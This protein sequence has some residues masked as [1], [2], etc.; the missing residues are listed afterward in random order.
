MEPRQSLSSRA[1][2]DFD[3]VR[4]SIASPEKIR[5]WSWGE[6]TKPETIN[7]RTFKPEKDGLFC[8]KIFGPINDFECLC[9]KYKRMKY[10]GIICER[11]GVEVTKSKVRRER[12]GHI[13]LASPVAHIWFFKSPPSRIGLVLDLTIKDLEKVLYFESYIVTEPGET[14]LKEKQ[15]L[16]EEEFKEAQEKYGDK[17]E[18][19]IGAEAIDSLLTRIDTSKEAE[20]LRKMM[21]K[22]TSQQRR[23]RYAKRLRVFKALKK[24]GNRPDWMV[25]KVIPVIPPDLRPLV[26][27]DGGRFAT[28]DLNDLYR[29][30]INRNNRLKKLIELKAPELIIRNEKRMLQEAVDALFDNGKRGRVHLG[31]NRRP[32]KSLSEALR[33]KQGRFR[34]NLLGKRVDYSGR[35][36][37]VVG[38]ELKLNQCG[39]P[40][41]MA[42]EL[43]KPFIFHKLEKEGLVPSVK[44]AREW[45]EA[46]RPEVWDY[47]EEVVREHPILLN[48]A[49]TLHRLGIQAF[50]PILIEGKAIQIHPLVCAAFNADFDGDQMAVHIP[51][52]VEAQIEAQTLMLSTNNILSPAHG[53]PLTIPSQ[54][55]VLGCYY[56]TLEKKGLRGEGR[57]F[58]SPDEALLALENKEIGLQARVKLRFKGRFMN[59][60]TYYDDQAV[61]TCP[62]TDVQNTLVDTTPGRIIFNNI[63]PRELPY[64]N[65]MLRKKGLESLVTYT[66][67]K[68]GPALTIETLDKLKET[69]F[70]QATQAGFSLGIDD[71]VV[72]KE[73]KELVE[74]AQK[75]VQEVERQYRDGTISSGERFNRVVEIWGTVTDKVSN[76]MFEEMKRL[77]FEGAELNPL[78]VMA[79]SGSRGNKQ[80]I[81]QLAGMRG[82]MSK[83]SGEI[84]ETPIVSNLREGLNVVQYFIS[85][86]GARKG[87]A[88]TALK[89]ANS[90]YLTR[91][92]VDVAQEVIVDE[93]DCGT[94]KGVNITAIVENGEIIEPFI[95]RIVG[96]TALEKVVNPDTNEVI[97]EP[98]QEITEAIAQQFQNLGI[99]K[100]RIRSLLTCEAKRGI[101]QLCYGRNLSTG[102]SAELGEAVGII[103]AQS[104]GEPGTQLTMRTFHIGGIAMRGEERSKLEAKNDGVIMFNNLK[105]VQNK[106]GTLVVV[107]R[108]ANIA[109]LDHRGREVEHYQVPYGAGI[110]VK[111]GD[112]VKAR[113]PFAEWDPFNTFILTDEAGVVQLHDVVIGLTMEEVQDDF[114]GLI[115]QVVIEPKDEKMQPRIEVVHP[116]KKDKNGKPQILRRYYLPSG[117]HLEAKGEDQVSAGDILA[118]IPREVA[119]TKDITGGLPRAEELFEARRPK[120]PAVIS[121]IDGNVQFGGLVRGYRKLVVIN[122]KGGEKEYLIP[123]GAH[124]SVGEGERVRAGTALMEGPVNPHDI[125]RVLGEKELA[126]YM[127][128]EV[129]AVYRLQGVTINDKHIEI[130]I[131]QMLRWIKVEEIGDTEFLVDEQ[132]DKFIFQEENEKVM[133]KGGKPAK[134]RP[135]LLGITKSALSTDSFIAAASFQETT[136]VLTEASLYG[137]VD[138]L[139]RLKENIIMGRLIPAGTGYRYYRDVELKEPAG[140]IEEPEI[141]APAR[142]DRTG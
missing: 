114:T 11:C 105:G 117:A 10:R 20:R 68:V 84:L 21:K 107:N 25:L 53:R 124:L 106:E 132:V 96:R 80:Q 45:H 2:V 23:L 48:R 130:I 138:Y 71:F 33:G 7:Y 17:F 77:S 128:R 73:K 76:A 5:S 42:L 61:M 109:I 92:L 110:F 12:M 29:R 89:T 66:Y 56:L 140:E 121:E 8:A 116:T 24:S 118:K 38:P 137:K 87:L 100:V 40:K 22:E 72:P 141:E 58:H 36:V 113:Q 115:T 15:L 103:A 4:I 44:I 67:L 91:K 37:I 62:V 26:R 122:E 69:G 127:V 46:E 119:R 98:N 49:P 78:F 136:R 64:I 79:D 104:I 129:Q 63:L 101:C 75:E 112:P 126:E 65:G 99:E 102:A 135:L 32:L 81:R 82:L 142:D 52:S 88:D 27:L 13:Q 70:I 125:L 59:L 6:V 3:R 57:I 85:T 139:R 39:L 120:N 94:L 19:S 51:L 41:K 131:R 9:G 54:D 1:K 134:A 35:S 74:N 86:H 83:P 133:K 93:P 55:M 18:A 95:D 14:P 123:K 30:V 16:N 60:A 31:A 28:S 43:F 108:N 50:E 34:Q 97:V 90:G 47:L 111:D